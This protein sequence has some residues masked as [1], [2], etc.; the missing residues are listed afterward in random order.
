MLM[1]CKSLPILRLNEGAALLK[2]AGGIGFFN[3]PLSDIEA[4]E[5][6]VE[7]RDLTPALLTSF[8]CRASVRLRR[9]LCAAY[10][11]N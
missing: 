3:R 4:L 7:N 8:E 11:N 5:S 6:R 1:R 2:A 10:I 9:T